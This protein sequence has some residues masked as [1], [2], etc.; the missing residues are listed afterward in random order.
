MKSKSAP[1]I[2]STEIYDVDLTVWW[3]WALIPGL[4]CIS[5]LHKLPND[6]LCLISDHKL[7]VAFAFWQY[8][9]SFSLRSP[10]KPRSCLMVTSP[11]SLHCLCTRISLLSSSITCPVGEW[12][13]RRYHPQ[14]CR[15]N[16]S[17]GSQCLHSVLWSRS[18][19]TLLTDWLPALELT[20]VELSCHGLAN[21]SP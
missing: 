11:S 3:F 9:A 4:V 16:H 20:L 18:E 14:K 8:P 12:A 2:V 15:L 5:Q 1:P 6:M 19:V 13:V 21:Q 10:S 7:L 17:P